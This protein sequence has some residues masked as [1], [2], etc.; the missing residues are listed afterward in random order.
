MFVRNLI[1]KENHL[2][3]PGIA[4][5]GMWWVVSPPWR[6]WFSKHRWEAGRM[7]EVCFRKVKRVSVCLENGNTKQRGEGLNHHH[8]GNQHHEIFS[9]H[10]EVPALN[11]SL[12]RPVF[13]CWVNRELKK[14]PLPIK[15]H[16]ENNPKSS[17]LQ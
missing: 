11:G 17:S 13:F 10:Q 3:A 2:L 14:S 8:L 12:E 7:L 9:P 4:T 6:A 5:A 16:G 15:T 1:S